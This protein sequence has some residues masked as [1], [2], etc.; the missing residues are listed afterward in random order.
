M[1][2]F[3]NNDNKTESDCFINTVS[4]G[5][6]FAGGFYL[7]PEAIANDGL[8]DVC[9][10]K[11]LNLIQRLKILMMVPK[12]THIHDEKVN[13]FRA[14]KLMLEFKDEVPFHIDGE[15]YFSKLFDI[16]ILPEALNVIYK[17]AGPHFFK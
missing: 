15:L 6:R 13:Y 7:T 5:R 9:S 8:L 16:N 4:I 1:M 14:E 2:I 10:I 11:K 12:G 17:P 3:S